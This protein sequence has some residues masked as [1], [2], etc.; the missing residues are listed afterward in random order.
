VRDE[1]NRLEYFNNTIGIGF[2]AV[3][4]I[5]TRKIKA[6]HGF[7]MYLIATLKTIF[8]DFAPMD[9]QVKTDQESWQQPTIMLTLGNGPR[10]GGGF[11]VTPQA[12]VDDGILHYATISRISRATMLRL[13]PEVMRGT[14]ARFSQVRMGTCR[15]MVVHSQQPLYVHCD[16]EIFAGFDARIFQLSLEILPHALQFMK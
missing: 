10:E 8:L 4:T 3:V 2:D 16:G 6:I 7:M 1:H 13:V 12:L 11:M 15:S 14:H 9:L 5:H